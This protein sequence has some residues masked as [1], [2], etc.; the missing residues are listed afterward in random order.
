MVIDRDGKVIDTLIPS[1][2]FSSSSWAQ[3]ELQEADKLGLLDS[4]IDYV[5]DR[6]ISRMKFCALIVDMCETYL[7][8]E[9]PV[10]T[11]NPFRD[12]DY[13]DVKDQKDII[14]KAYAAGIVNGTDAT[15]LVQVPPLTANRW[16]P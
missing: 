9:M 16:Q 1:K 14:L 5:F 3:A 11:S 4:V 13:D 10:S 12:L 7:G 8:K 15:T 2:Y 6:D